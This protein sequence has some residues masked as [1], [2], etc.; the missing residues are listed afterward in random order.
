[1]LFGPV[2]IAII[3]FS[4]PFTQPAQTQPPAPQ[5]SSSNST[6][7]PQANSSVSPPSSSL[8]NTAPTIN[9]SVSPT[10]GSALFWQL[11]TKATVENVCLTA[12]KKTAVAEGYN[13]D[14]VSG[15]SCTSNETQD[16]KSY[17]CQIT[18]LDGTHGANITCSNIQQ[19]CSIE[20]Q[21]GTETYTFGE[22]TAMSNNQ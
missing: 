19:T 12:A 5:P 21:H 22:L 20:T 11:I 9:T 3:L 18:A 15:C 2:L 4:C 6:V 13:A 1:M 14:V 8:N 16:I 10:L 17:A 7:Q